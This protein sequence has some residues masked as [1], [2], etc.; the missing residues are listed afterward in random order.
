[1]NGLLKISLIALGG[2]C[3]SLARWWLSG[4]VYAIAGR[5]FPWGTVSVNVFGSFLFGLVWVLTER[6]I[7]FSGEIRLLLLVG[8]MGAFTTFSTYIFESSALASDLQWLRLG[9][10]MAG[11]VFVGFAALRLGF[12]CGNVL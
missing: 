7:H 5:D 12:V 8:F 6:R 4:V 3:G 10:N 9:L 11:Q 2:A 1:M